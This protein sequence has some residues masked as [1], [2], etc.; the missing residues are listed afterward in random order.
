MLSI[1]ITLRED[2]KCSLY[3]VTL[4]QSSGWLTFSSLDSIYSLISL[5][6][7]SSDADGGWTKR[8]QSFIDSD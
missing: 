1:V 8:R 5:L 3:Y 4:F 2:V 7:Q 6:S